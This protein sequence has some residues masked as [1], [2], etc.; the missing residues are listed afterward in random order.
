ML[1]TVNPGALHATTNAGETLLSL[2]TSTATKSHPNYALIDDLAERLENGGKKITPLRT[3]I[4]IL[5]YDTH[6]KKPDQ[7]P[8]PLSKPIQRKRK[9]TADEDDMDSATLLL[10]FSRQTDKKAKLFA[11]V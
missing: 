6:E 8:F 7:T 5:P 9:V 11:K 4:T 2:A 10:H 1:L 3:P